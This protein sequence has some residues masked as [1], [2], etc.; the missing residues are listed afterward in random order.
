MRNDDGLLVEQFIEMMVAERGCAANTS[1]AY[2]RDLN[3]FVEFA[4]RK[5]LR[6][7]TASADA[8]EKYSAS[9]HR[10]DFSPRSIARK[11]S[12]LRQFFHFL[13]SEKIRGDD[14]AATVDSPKQGRPLPKCLSESDIEALIAEAHKP[15]NA[16]SRR[17]VALLEILYGSGLRVTELI[18]L[19]VTA[20][21]NVKAT[22]A[23]PFLMIKGKGGKERIAPLSPNAIA[24][25]SD[26]MT[27]RDSFLKKDEKSPWLFPSRGKLGHLTRQRFGQMLKELAVLAGID[28][29]KISP[30]TL[31][32]SFASHMLAGGADLRVIQELLGHSDISTTQI[33]THVQKEK[34]VKLVT[35]HHP[36]SKKSSS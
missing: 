30:H 5:K 8:I 14:P 12:C 27:F 4:R 29:E 33:Y 1:A 24:A 34:L 6:L 25:L 17:L 26:Y 20:V 2:L 19:K 28:P 21:Q 22:T 31:R 7:M 35:E 11:L 9:L 16:E 13:Y 15:Q 3:D 32:H 36:M 23:L 10:A 18:S